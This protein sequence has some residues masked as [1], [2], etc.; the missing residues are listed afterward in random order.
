MRRSL[1]FLLLALGACSRKSGGSS[2]DVVLATAGGSLSDRAVGIL[3]LD[4]THVYF[5]DGYRGDAKL[6]R[7]AKTGGKAETVAHIGENV[8]ALALDDANAYVATDE[9]I[10]RVAKAG[11]KPASIASEK[12]S[13]FSRC[14]LALDATHAYFTT[15][16]GVRRVAKAGGAAADVAATS[17]EASSVALDDAHVYWVDG[18]GIT[19]A[20][21]AGG[22]AQVIAKMTGSTHDSI[23]VDAGRVYW[24]DGTTAWS[25]PVAGGTPLRL[26]SAPHHHKGFAVDAKYVYLAMNRSDD[27]T[28]FDKGGFVRAPRAGGGTTEN[29]VLGSADPKAI[30]ADD[31]A[32][33][34]VGVGTIVRTP[35]P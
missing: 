16:T 1:V 26:G 18:A 22:A 32:V 6:V 4:A 30:A 7:V 19:R 31:G 27:P 10:Q 24:T 17:S 11:G 3:A 25:A 5:I 28:S 21:K 23:F 15:K 33:Y 20:P 14:G 8:G 29:V 13:C 12:T 9:A 35:K 2:T 34:W